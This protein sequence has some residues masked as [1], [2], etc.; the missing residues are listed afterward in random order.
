[1]KEMNSSVWTLHYPSL[2]A[3]SALLPIMIAIAILI[4]NVLVLMTFKKMTGLQIQH[5]FMIGLTIADLMTVLP[6]SVTS[7]ILLSRKIWLTNHLCAMLGISLNVAIEMT[8]LMHTAMSAEKCLA[9]SSPLRHRSL[10]HSKWFRRSTIMSIAFCFLFPAIFNFSLFFA[11]L[12]RFIF[13]SAITTCVT[14]QS[15]NIISTLC[16]GVMFTFLPMIMQIITQVYMLVKVKKQRGVTRKQTIKAIKTVVLTVGVYWL[17]WL[18]V[19]CQL[20]FALFGSLPPGW[21]RFLAL[22]IVQANSA[23]SYIIYYT[24]LPNFKLS[25]DRLFGK[26]TRII[27]VQQFN[28]SDQNQTAVNSICIVPRS[29]LVAPVMESM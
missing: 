24:S 7:F 28:A 13:S 19:A 15:N 2:P 14:D 29:A 26:R 3:A 4:N 17:F 1:M 8:T 10:S 18:P 6:V 27:H 12:V 11:N 20:G 21:Y 5:Y 22:Q 16:I 23:T 25:S 9:I